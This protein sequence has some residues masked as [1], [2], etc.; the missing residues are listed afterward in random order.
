MCFAHEME[1]AIRRQTRSYQ[2]SFNRTLR[3]L[4]LSLK[5]YTAG[6]AIELPIGLLI[7]L[8]A[9]RVKETT[10]FASVHTQ[11]LPCWFQRVSRKNNTT[12]LVLQVLK[13]CFG[14]A[15]MVEKGQLTD[16]IVTI[17]LS[18]PLSMLCAQQPT[19]DDVLA[20]SRFQRQVFMRYHSDNRLDRRWGHPRP[21]VQ[22][23]ELDQRWT[24]MPVRL[25]RAA[26]VEPPWS[27][28]YKIE[29]RNA[30]TQ[31]NNKPPHS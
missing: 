1:D 15:E 2:S 27:Y 4:S 28:N 30:G 14:T 6:P 22:T 26:P 23:V 29:S 5:R 8:A 11:A 20:G 18:Q 19:H 25:T 12:G 9:V 13:V 7:R 31:D 16:F 17:P 10:S 24:H 3:S 21:R